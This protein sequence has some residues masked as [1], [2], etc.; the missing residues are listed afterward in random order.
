[1]VAGWQVFAIVA[2]QFGSEMLFSEG[3]WHFYEYKHMPQRIQEES[4]QK[5]K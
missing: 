3:N 1:M 4:H 2:E 5:E